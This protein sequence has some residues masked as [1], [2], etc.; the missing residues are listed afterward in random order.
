M[1]R[2][3]STTAARRPII[4]L[5]PDGAARDFLIELNEGPVVHTTDAKAIYRAV[6]SLLIDRPRTERSASA[7]VR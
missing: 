6:R 5:V 4:G 1:H 7:I 2:S 3:S